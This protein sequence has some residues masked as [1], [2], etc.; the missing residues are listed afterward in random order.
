MSK[1]IRAIQSPIA[2]ELAARFAGYRPSRINHGEAIRVRAG[3]CVC[4]RPI[5]D[6]FDATNRK[7]SCET[8]AQLWADEGR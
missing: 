5:A 6:H 8:I 7:H 1:T 2:R 3:L 4:G